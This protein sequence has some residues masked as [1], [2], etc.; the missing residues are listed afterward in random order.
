MRAAI[1]DRVSLAAAGCAF[2][3][4]MALF[5]AISILISVYGLVFNV[6]PV[7]QQLALSCANCCRRR[8]SH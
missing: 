2:Y 8:P 5:P 4:T 7:E 6:Q 3:A 1:T